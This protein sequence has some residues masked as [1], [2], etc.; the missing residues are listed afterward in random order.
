MLCRF[1]ISGSFSFIVWGN[2]RVVS[3]VIVPT[4][5]YADNVGVVGDAVSGGEDPF[6]V[7]DAAAAEIEPVVDSDAGLPGEFAYGGGVEN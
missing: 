4:Y 3:S 6:F 2:V 7:E 1:D 5:G